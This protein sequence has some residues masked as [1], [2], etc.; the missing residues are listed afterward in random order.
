[1]PISL[2]TQQ[3]LD[4]NL[5]LQRQVTDYA[6]ELEERSLEA[7]HAKRQLEQM[8]RS[9]TCQVCMERRVDTLLNG[10]GH[11]LCAQ[12]IGRIAAPDIEDRCPYCRREF[13][14]TT[15]LRW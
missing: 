3:L 7:S 4:A 6:K 14:G 5:S 11:M 1:M 9:T 13:S 15:K 10:C 2:E 12:C 8:Q